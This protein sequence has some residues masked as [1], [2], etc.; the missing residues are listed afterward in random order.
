MNKEKV[1]ELCSNLY[2]NPF[3]QPTD[4]KINSHFEIMEQLCFDKQVVNLGI[5]GSSVFGVKLKVI[6]ASAKVLSLREGKLTG[7]NQSTSPKLVSID[8]QLPCDVRPYSSINIDCKLDF[9]D[10]EDGFHSNLLW[11]T[12]EDGLRIATQI[13]YVLQSSLN[14]KSDRKF[15]KE[16]K[17][18]YKYSH[19]FNPRAEKQTINVNLVS[20]NSVIYA[21]STSQSVYW[22]KCLSHGG[23]FI[24]Y[25][26]PIGKNLFAVEVNQ[27]LP[28]ETLISFQ[29]NEEKPLNSFTT[30]NCHIGGCFKL[31]NQLS[32]PSANFEMVINKVPIKDD[33]LILKKPLWLDLELKKSGRK[34]IIYGFILQELT[35]QKVDSEEVILKNSI[36][37]ISFLINFKFDNRSIDIVEVSSINILN[38]QESE[39]SHYIATCTLKC[40]GIGACTVIIPIPEIQHSGNI[41]QSMDSPNVK[42]YTLKIEKN[43]MITKHS[44]EDKIPLI[45]T[46]DLGHIRYFNVSL[47]T[48]PNNGRINRGILGPIP[49][50]QCQSLSYSLPIHNSRNQSSNILDFNLSISGAIID[51]QKFSIKRDRNYFYLYNKKN[52]FN[53]EKEVF[54]KLNFSI[55]EELDIRHYTWD[56]I[57]QPI[58]ANLDYEV[59]KLEYGGVEFTHRLFQ[60]SIANNSS[61]L[62]LISSIFSNSMEVHIDIQP[63]LRQK[64]IFIDPGDVFL[65][66]AASQKFL[67]NT[68][69]AVISIFYNNHAPLEIDLNKY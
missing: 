34:L 23:D 1:Y 67:N 53:Q 24:Q 13:Q 19:F 39:S 69:A 38:D 17:F 43:W 2:N 54:G 49:F 41:E 15:S 65:F 21:T 16:Q 9:S 7:L 20:P 37:E 18:F 46:N 25:L 4:E 47:N 57:L 10:L 28:L 6:N 5:V 56:I 27:R 11:L 31:F 50:F 33:F 61:K 30:R 45:F 12:Q 55:S 68:R 51:P 3:G 32:T 66:N 44:A 52:E 26:M 35:I 40:F 22:V 8:P 59:K 29:D 64:K 48:L 60:I 36:G 63:L 62:A 42:I 14:K 58:E